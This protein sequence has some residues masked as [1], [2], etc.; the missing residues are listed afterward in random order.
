MTEA[1][2]RT[3]HTLRSLPGP[4]VTRVCIRVDGGYRWG[5]SIPAAAPAYL[6]AAALDD[7]AEVVARSPAAPYARIPTLVDGRTTVYPA[8][9]TPVLL[10]DT[11]FGDQ[12]SAAQPIVER[13]FRGLGTFLAHLHAIPVVERV[14]ELRPRSQPAWLEA[15]PDAAD[16]IHAARTHLTGSLAPLISR[17]ADIAASSPLS[18]HVLTLVHGRLSTGSCVPG[19]V[20]GVLGWREAGLADP[21]ADLAFLL[22]DLVQ[23]AAA[24]GDQERQAHR[25]HLVVSGY[26]ETRGATLSSGEHLR[27]AGRLASCVL[28]HVAL[29]SWTAA[30]PQGAAALL[31]RAERALPNILNAIGASEAVDRP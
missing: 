27:L 24:M 10:S 5:E 21:M 9:A 20:P 17:L 18:T 3:E 25:A 1:A 2:S 7:L 16:G 28:D 12:T 6:D 8:V 31:Q 11:V 22:R 14:A 13:A 4:F 26:E 29:R 19:T 15:A 23:A 30:D